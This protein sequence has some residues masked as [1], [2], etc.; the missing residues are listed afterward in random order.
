MFAHNKVDSLY[1]FAGTEEYFSTISSP[2]R[3]IIKDVVEIRATDNEWD[4]LSCKEREKV[5]DERLID[6]AAPKAQKYHTLDSKRRNKN[7]YNQ[8]SV[9]LSTFGG[10]DQV[11]PRL[12]IDSGQKKQTVVDETDDSCV[13][14]PISLKRIRKIICGSSVFEAHNIL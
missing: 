10:V 8:Q 12:K 7:K 4:N 2:A 3:R 11:F 13:S 6:I 5:L 14:A 1:F 9:R